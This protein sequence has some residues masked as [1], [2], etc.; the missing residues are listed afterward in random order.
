MSKVFEMSLRV[1]LESFLHSSDYQFGFKAN[2]STDLCRPIYTLK[3]VIYFYKYQSTSI[4]V[5]FMDACKAFDRVNHWLLFKKLI[6]R[7]MP[8]IL[9][10]ILMEWYTTQKACVRWGSAVSN[11]FVVTNGVRQ[12]GILSPLLFNVYMDGLSSS[13]SNTPTGCAIGGVMVNHIMYADDLVII[14]P[15]VKG[16]QRLLHVCAVY[17]QTHDILFNDDK[18]V[19]M[20]MPV[21]SS[22]YINT[23]ALFLNGR[24]L[25]FT[26]KYKYLGTL[27]THDGSD[28]ANMSRQRGFFLCAQQCLSK[29]FNACSPSVK[30]TLFR[31]FCSNMYCGHLWHDFRK[32]ALR[33]LIVGYNHSFRFLMKFD[34]NCSASGMFVSNCIPSFME[35]WR[36]PKYIYGFT[37]RLANSDNAIVA[38]I[39]SSCRLSS[40]FWKR[41]DSLLYT[42]SELY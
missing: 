8:L 41:W 2:H 9:V 30:A 24:R 36:R 16:L 1:K 15:S 28:E 32:S 17:G 5:C 25:T 42:A 33:R 29:N 6:D 38:A 4:Y 34:R 21:K 37:Q 13:L 40:N 3:E 39:V 31:T 18:T 20:F 23:P 22:F 7:G 14:S 10:R 35:I 19:C 26:V 11:S 12:G 27:I